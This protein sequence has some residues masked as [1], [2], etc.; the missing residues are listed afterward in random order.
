MSERFLGQR[1]KHKR[2]LW[3]AKYKR[4]RRIERMIRRAGKDILDSERFLSTRGHIQHG[5]ITVHDHCISVARASIKI[6][7]TLKLKCNKKELIRGAL[8]HD[9]F[10][11]DWHKGDA[12]R[13]ENLHGLYHP[14]IAL[15]NA[16]RDFDLTDREKDIIK[17]HMWPLTFIPPVYREGWVVTVADKWCST[18]ETLKIRKGHGI[19]ISEVEKVS[20][21][22]K[23]DGKK[24]GSVDFLE[25]KNEILMEQSKRQRRKG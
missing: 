10:L 18:L 21:R 20:L 2:A 3:I 16:S 4:H 19:V 15:R 23:E 17:K 14:G 11:Y 9:Y 1:N 6:A 25:A 7:D 24:S 12:A 5:N 13:P 8:L 22:A